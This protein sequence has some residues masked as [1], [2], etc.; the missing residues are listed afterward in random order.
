M[1]GLRILR[2]EVNPAAVLPL[3]GGCTNVNHRAE[4]V[5][6][7]QEVKRHENNDPGKSIKLG[8]VAHL[9]QKNVLT[10][11]HISNICTSRSEPVN[12]TTEFQGKPVKHPTDLQV[13][14]AWEDL[15]TR[16]TCTVGGGEG[17]SGGAAEPSVVVRVRRL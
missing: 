17:G 6:G 13:M 3:Q 9:H 12:Y 1:C 2:L 5:T 16:K 4:C 7:L 14:S 11:T 10:R 8:T 15:R